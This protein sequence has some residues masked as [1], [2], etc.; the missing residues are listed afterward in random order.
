MKSLI[1]NRLCAVAACALLVPVAAQAE[2][3][4]VLFVYGSAWV[5]DVDGQRDA[6]ARGSLVESGDRIV[7]AANGRVQI[8]M[9]DGGMLALRPGTEFHIENYNDPSSPTAVVAGASAD[10]EARSFFT[11]VKGGFRSITGAIGQ[12]DKS[13]YRVRTP[14]ATIGIR[15]TDYYAQLCAGDC[16]SL[17]AP[18]GSAPADGLH[19]KVVEG[20]VYMR[21][22]AGTVEIDAGQFGYAAGGNMAPQLASGA[23]SAVVSRAATQPDADS[24]EAEASPVVASA[25]TDSAGNDVDLTVGEGSADASG[26]VAFSGGPNGVV[27]VSGAGSAGVSVD[28]NGAVTAFSGSDGTR[29]EQ[30]TADSVN[31]G[32][33]A[34]RD[35][36]TNLT[37]GRWSSGAIDVTTAA[38]TESQS[39]DT[40]SV[41]WVAGPD[42]NPTPTLPTEGTANFELVGNTNPTDNRGNVGTLGSANLSAD[43]TNQTVDADVS[44]AIDQASEV[45]DASATDVDMNSADAT[46]G[47]EFDTVTVTDTETGTQSTDANGSLD[48]FFSGDAD[49]NLNGAGMSYTLGDDAGTE[50]S[51]AAAF[52]VED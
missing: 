33:D 39:L 21:N 7:T 30:G 16:A 52:Q 12:N 15:G 32:R 23:S 20:G 10:S 40:S 29:F 48:G 14:V 37:W 46:F 2:A 41:H 34:D 31:V 11:L 35:G 25:A 19:V 42:G 49:G 13:A 22:D 24:A 50:V 17:R 1:L 26:A 51:G 28:G 43:F 27:D 4:K 8:R 18:D 38:G 47:G 45:W 3:G 9:S 36:A 5:Q 44:L 6:L